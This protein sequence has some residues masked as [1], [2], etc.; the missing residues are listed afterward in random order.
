MLR[1]LLLIHWGSQ[2]YLRRHDDFSKNQEG[3]FFPQGILFF[4]RVPG[5][6]RQFRLKSRTSVASS[7][8]FS[9]KSSIYAYASILPRSFNLIVLTLWAHGGKCK[10]DLLLLIGECME[11]T[12]FTDIQDKPVQD[13]G[14]STRALHCF[15]AHSI[16]TVGDLLKYTPEGLLGL[17]CFGSKTLHQVR[18]LLW[19]YGLFLRDDRAIHQEWSME[20]SI[21]KSDRRE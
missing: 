17:R 11:H 18:R 13:F 1:V 7:L 8:I 3:W 14:F 5:G 21:T 9:C 15:R 20:I 19:S 12:S 6:Q 4:L 10:A 16:R 2:W